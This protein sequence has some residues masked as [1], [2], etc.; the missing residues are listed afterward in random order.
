MNT[1]CGSYIIDC[2]GRILLCHPNTLPQQIWSI[3][4][5]VCDENESFYGAACREL[6]EETGITIDS[7]KCK[8]YYIGSI[9]YTSKVR[10]DNKMLHGFVFQLEGT[11]DY[12]LVCTSW[13]SKGYLEVD[14]HEWVE[15]NTA[16][17]MIQDEQRT[18]FLNSTWTKI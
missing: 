6:Y 14:Q 10:H 11:V 8:K 16:L 7:H 18:L 17:T 2:K 3:P 1:T 9:P 12:E 4:K 15:R 13:T 5:G